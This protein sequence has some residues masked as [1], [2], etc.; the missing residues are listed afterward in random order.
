M[1]GWQGQ[2]LPGNTRRRILRQAHGVCQ[3]CGGARCGNRSLQVDHRIPVAEGGTNDDHNLWAIGA[4]PCHADKTR[5][6]Q[7][8]GR[9]RKT[10]TRPRE[11]HPG[12][13]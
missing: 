5:A 3:A 13:I 4:N 9:V 11:P 8:R 2:P 7:Q 12:L 10:R 1:A 6:E